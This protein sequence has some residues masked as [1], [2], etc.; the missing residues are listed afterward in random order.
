MLEKNYSN[1]DE[2]DIVSKYTLEDFK[3]YYKQ[4]KQIIVP[5]VRLDK[6]ILVSKKA[7]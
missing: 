1:L 6:T 4:S 7:Y 2:F 3:K 5:R